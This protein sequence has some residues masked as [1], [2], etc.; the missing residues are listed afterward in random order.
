VIDF[1]RTYN[2]VDGRLVW[3]WSLGPG[4]GLQWVVGAAVDNSREDRRGYRNFLGTPI[5]PTTLGVTGDKR[6]DE[7]NTAA[8]S[9][10]YAQGDLEFAPGLVGTLGM[11]QGRVRYRSSDRFIEPGNGDDSGSIAYRYST[12]VAALQ[13]QPFRSVQVYLSA[14]NGF[15]APTLNEIAYRSTEVSG[16]N[17]GLKPQTSRQAELGFKWRSDP[18]PSSLH[19]AVDAAI[20]RADTRDEI[21]VESNSGGRS[22][23]RNV[24][25]THRQGAELDAK[26]VLSPAWRGQMALSWLDATYRDSFFVPAG[27]ASPPC[28]VPSGNRIAGTLRETAYAEIAWLPTRSLEFALEARG[29]GRL[30]VN[31]VNGDF[32]AGFG[33]LALR[34]QW[35]L[36]L[37]AGRLGLLARIDNLADRRVVSSVIVNESLRRFFEPAPG[38]SGLLSARWSA[39]F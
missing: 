24:G 13:W 38:R 35:R 37:G 34:A 1:D 27:C 7:L 30:P 5:V 9:D 3:S 20:F 4:R 14:G 17:T 18:G 15:E 23:F 6:R 29:Q 32:A 36:N 39:P 31:D 26:F 12:P 21:A 8:R 2:G 10:V 16:I 25:R 22:V 33:L 28:R 11:R 19:M